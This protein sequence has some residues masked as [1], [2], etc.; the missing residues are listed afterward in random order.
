MQKKSIF[1]WKNQ[2]LTKGTA[3]QPILKPG[4]KRAAPP[5]QNVIDQM[6][7]RNTLVVSSVT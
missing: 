5:Q 2:P 4:I 6:T 7:A 1:P 3:M